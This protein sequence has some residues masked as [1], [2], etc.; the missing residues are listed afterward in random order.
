MEEKPTKSVTRSL[1]LWRFT[2][3]GLW[4]ASSAIILAG[5]SRHS[6]VGKGTRAAEERNVGLLFDP[7]DL[8]LGEV[9]AGETVEFQVSVSNNSG[10]TLRIVGGRSGC[11]C[12]LAKD[13]PLDVPD[14]CSSIKLEFAFRTPGEVPSKTRVEYEAH[15]FVAGRG[16][17]RPIR[18]VADIVPDEKNHD[19]PLVPI[20]AVDG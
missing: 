11:G 13:L 18:V 8:S 17:S 16:W 15:L 2:A 1:V 3:I 5:A 12:L 10:S 9:V 7:C 4:M 20:P 19:S 6:F 14:N